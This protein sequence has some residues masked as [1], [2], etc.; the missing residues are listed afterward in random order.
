MENKSKNLLI[1]S[2]LIISAVIFLVIIIYFYISFKKTKEETNRER[3]F[4]Y[5]TTTYKNDTLSSKSPLLGLLN[6]NFEEVPNTLSIDA[7]IKS[8]LMASSKMNEIGVD[9]IYN[10]IC[11]MSK[12]E[13]MNKSN[14][15][16]NGN[17][18]CYYRKNVLNENINCD[19]IC[20]M[21]T[22]DIMVQINNDLYM[23]HE[24][25]F[26]EMFPWT[27]QYVK[28]YHIKQGPLEEILDVD[29]LTML[30]RLDNM[31]YDRDLF[32]SAIKEVDDQ[33][34]IRFWLE[35][36]FFEVYLK[37]VSKSDSM[38]LLAK[39]YQ[40]PPTR[41]IAAGDAE[42]D[43]EMLQSAGISIAMKNAH[44]LVK[45][46]ATT[47]SDFDNNHDGLYRALKEIFH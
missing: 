46:C 20:S 32:L 45:K 29:P 33:I 6:Y 38:L 4:T 28:D 37:G 36:P 41:I 43:I 14:Y 9:N 27:R 19:N 17:T 26:F 13:Y 2:I 21:S 42:N 11:G 3:V 1:K 5:L 22:S 18:N 34:G 7:L 23:E 24:E 44:D 10:D 40:I 12:N 16:L 31:Q 15:L 47:I 8:N 30:V 35:A 39:R 25:N